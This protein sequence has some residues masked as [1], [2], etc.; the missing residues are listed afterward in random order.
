MFTLFTLTKVQLKLNHLRFLYQL[1]LVE[2]LGLHGGAVVSAPAFQQ[3]NP[4]A[5]PRWKT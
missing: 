4:S 5:S 3:E 2:L 1:G